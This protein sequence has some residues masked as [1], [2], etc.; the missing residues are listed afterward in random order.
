MSDVHVVSG[1]VTTAPSAIVPRSE[2]QLFGHYYDDERPVTA[3]PDNT[4]LRATAADIGVAAFG[5]HLVSAVP[6]GPGEMDL[7]FWAAGQA[8]SW[9]EQDHRAWGFSAEGGYQW[10]KAPWAP[11]L[12]LGYSLV[13]GDDDRADATHGTFFPMLPT[14]RRYSQSTLYS[15]ANLR[16]AFVTVIARPRANVTI[17]VDAHRLG[18]D[19]AAD[20]WYAGSGATQEEGRIFGYTLRPSGGETALMNLVESSVD[21]RFSP[22]WSVNGYVGVG[23]RGSAVRTS[24]AG[25]PAT[26]AYVENVIQWP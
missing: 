10:A 3:R 5:G 23:S 8:G 7:L 6:T 21:W 1:V 2:L 12:R 15:L 18:L 26:F 13:S 24:F 17:R 25:G 14:V 9:Y 16:D 22:R 20:G 11:W 19:S 4:G